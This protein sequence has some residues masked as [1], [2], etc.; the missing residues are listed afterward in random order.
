M[1]YTPRSLFRLVE[2]IDAHRLL[3]P[4][5]QRAFVWEPEQMARLFDSLMRDYPIQTFLFWRTKEEIRARTFMPAVDPDADLSRFY[6]LAK[7]ANGVEKTF[8]LDGQQRLQTLHAIFSG[9]ILADTGRLKE[10]YCELTDGEG[11]VDNGNTLHRLVFSADPLPLPWFRVRDLVERCGNGNPSTIADELNDA[12]EQVLPTETSE[13]RRSR[14]RR[15]RA[16][17]QQLSQILNQDKFFYIDELDGVATAAAFPYRKILEIFVR[18]NSGGTKLTSG[19]LMFAA[20][21]EGWDDIEQRVEQTVDLLNGGRLSI[22]SDFVLK[23]LLL[24]Q[25]EGAEVQ[26]EKFFGSK[27]EALLKRIED[28]WDQ[29]ETA[30]QQLRDFMVHSLRIESDRL[31]RSYNAL[32]PLFDFLFHNK[33]PDEPT[34]A[35]MAGYY[36]KSQ[37]FGWYS[38]QTDSVLNAL[39]GIV[40]KDTGGTFPIDAIKTHFRN[41]GSSVELQELY[42]NDKHL[43]P[44]ILNMVYCDRWG[45]SPFNVAFKGNEPHVDHIYPQYMLRSKLGLGTSE[46]N[47]IGNLRFVGATDNIRKRAELPNSYFARLKQ[48]GIPIEKHLLVRSY[49]DNPADLK[50]DRLTFDAFRQERRAGIW[51]SAKSM[52][53]PEC[54]TDPAED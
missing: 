27:G 5:I 20:M 41:R 51:R 14:E 35:L 24:A 9:G 42:L 25:D 7:S 11:G 37:L 52:V 23:C 31:V 6:D 8:V 3:L 50:F 15:V 26:T 43:R 21:K 54:R 10:A 2:D 32:I 4:H 46:I 49:A 30:F 12:L 53:D 19:D 28:T 33:Q 38:R 39:H 44:I 18:V 13:L 17:V 34:R 47:D 45:A 40:G 16:N 1:S 29:A 22:D 36:N 48:A